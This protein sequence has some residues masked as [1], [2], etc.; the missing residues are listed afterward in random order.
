MRMLS[1]AVADTELLW[2]PLSGTTRPD[3]A[4]IERSAM[5]LAG[6]GQMCSFVVIF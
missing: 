3:E 2:G 1:V 5:N 6:F 4:V